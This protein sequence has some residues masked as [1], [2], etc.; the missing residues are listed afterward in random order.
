[1][2]RNCPCWRVIDGPISPRLSGKRV[3]LLVADGSHEHE[4]WTPYYRLKEE[5][6]TVIVAGEKAGVTHRGEGLHGLDGL[7]LA[8]NDATIAELN[9]DQLDALILPGG[10]FG[11]LTLRVHE[12]TLDLVRKMDA[13]RKVIASIC[14]GQW[15][16]VSAG[17][18]RGRRA[19]CPGDM[20]VDLRNS[21]AEFVKEDVV[22]DG[23]LI[24]SIYYGYLPQFLK[25]VVD[26]I[27]G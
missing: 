24:T 4:V 1:M 9:A 2:A 13:Q 8:P 27:E 12:P 23:N 25:A 16:L 22:R 26:A 6:A 3:A 17:I 15:I 14:H 20:A 10:I 18:L 5:G 11:P 7:K 19:T 21:G